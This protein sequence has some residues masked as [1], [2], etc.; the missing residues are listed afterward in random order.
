[1]VKKTHATDVDFIHAHSLI[2]CITCVTT[3]PLMRKIIR[4]LPD[5][6]V[7]IPNHLWTDEALFDSLG[8]SKE[9]VVGRELEGHAAPFQQLC[10]PVWAPVKYCP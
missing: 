8:T 7:L 5:L 4:L 9:E 6:L 1:M 3:N 2:P 10:H